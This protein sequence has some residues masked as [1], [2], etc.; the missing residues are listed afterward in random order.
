MGTDKF[1][2]VLVRRFKT[3]LV[4]MIKK[5]IETHVTFVSV[6]FSVDVLIWHW[7]IGLKNPPLVIFVRKE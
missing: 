4:P 2:I 6:G 5:K 7:G 3:Y 1:T